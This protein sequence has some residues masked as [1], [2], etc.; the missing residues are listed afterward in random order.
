MLE[1]TSTSNSLLRVPELVYPERSQFDA[2]RM[3]LRSWEAAQLLPLLYRGAPANW[4]VISLKKLLPCGIDPPKCRARPDLR[5]LLLRANTPRSA[6]IRAS[7][8][9]SPS[10]DRDR[11]RGLP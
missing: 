7:G 8:R 10:V 2:L 3:V 11:I 9:S 1:H 5:P 6:R 4:R